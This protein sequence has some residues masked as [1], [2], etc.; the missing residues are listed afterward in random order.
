MENV[1]G[2]EYFCFQLDNLLVLLFL[3]SSSLE[4]AKLAMP[5]K[6]SYDILTLT[7]PVSGLKGA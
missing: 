2:V 3:V 5:I 6:L 1:A 4:K 7:K